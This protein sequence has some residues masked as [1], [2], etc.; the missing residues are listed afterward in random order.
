MFNFS[1]ANLENKKFIRESG[2]NSGR[3]HYDG[4][5]VSLLNKM[6]QNDDGVKEFSEVTH[7]IKF[8][9]PTFD[10]FNLKDNS[11]TLINI[12]NNNTVIFA[13][14]TGDNGNLYL[15]PKSG[16]NKSKNIRNIFII[17]KLV[18]DGLLPEFESS[19]PLEEKVALK[20]RTVELSREE[21]DNAKEAGVF[22]NN[23]EDLQ[24]E[25]VTMF[26]LELDHEASKLNEEGEGSEESEEGEEL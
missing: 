20:F 23:G 13:V 14:L 6:K 19:T 17:N 2:A 8:Y 16:N 10:K 3:K 12:P 18:A 7:N 5:G 21:I 24:D 25:V 4:V 22:Q 11:L 9:Q 1:D 26:Y 15:K